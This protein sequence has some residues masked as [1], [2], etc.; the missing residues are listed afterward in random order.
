MCRSWPSS[1][2][3]AFRLGS[4]ATLSTPSWPSR[5]HQQG[6]AGRAFAEAFFDHKAAGQTV[7]GA[8]LKRIDDVFRRWRGELVL[9]VLQEVEELTHRGQAVFDR[10]AGAELDEILQFLSGPVHDLGNAQA[11]AETAFL[12]QLLDAGGWRPA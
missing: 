9:D 2:R 4:R 12:V 7:I 11:M 1:L 6:H 5:S 3:R 8:R 10:G